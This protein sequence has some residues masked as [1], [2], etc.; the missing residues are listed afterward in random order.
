MKQV[1]FCVETNKACNSDYLYIN[2]FIRF[3]YP[4]ILTKYKLS[5]L[6]LSGKGNYNK[7]GNKINLLKNKYLYQPAEL[8]NGTSNLGKV[9]ELLAEQ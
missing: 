2:S 8:V 1:V 3:F 5:V 7:K 4:T 9:L 6:Y